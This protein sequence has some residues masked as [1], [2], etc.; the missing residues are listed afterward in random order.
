MKPSSFSCV[1]IVNSSANQ[2]KVPS[3]SPSFARSSGRQH[4]GDHEDGRARGTR[5]P[6]RR[7]A[8]TDAAPQSATITTNVIVTIH[9]SRLSGPSAASAAR[10]A[11][12]ASGVAVTSGAH[13]LVEQARQ[14]RHRDQ[15]GHRRDQQPQAEPDLDAEL[16]RDLGAERVGGHRGQPERRRQAQAGDPREHQEAAEP[17]A[18][19]VAAAW[20][21][22]SPR[23]RPP[24]DTARR[25][26]RC[27]SGRPARSRRPPGTGCRPARAS[28]ARTG[29]PPRGRCAR[30]A[31][32]SPP[33]AP[34]GRRRR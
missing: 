31:R 6:S 27:C 18:R 10:A 8:M 20:R 9:S 29:S 5:P 19:R 24:A 4:A 28:S 14:Q 3:T 16:A 7:S 34:R 12:G 32:T 17:H 13:H 1:L 33:P 23:A 21:R 22:P 26:A 11:A 15:R 2:M 25:T 30:R